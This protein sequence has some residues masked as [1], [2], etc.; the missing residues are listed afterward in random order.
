[1][2]WASNQVSAAAAAKAT[3]NPPTAATTAAVTRKAMAMRNADPQV[4]T[5]SCGLTLSLG[6]GLSI[7]RVPP[8][9]L[10]L[11]LHANPRDVSSLCLE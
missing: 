4:K 6:S 11:S 10:G 8:V 7:I 9:I 3:S 5:V 2:E 1:M